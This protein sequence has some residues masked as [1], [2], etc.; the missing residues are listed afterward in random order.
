MAWNRSADN[1]RNPRGGQYCNGQKGRREIKVYSDNI[2]LRRPAYGCQS[3]LEQAA[4]QA[5]GALI[6]PRPRSRR[7]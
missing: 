2:G 7:W 4:R 1:I 3:A 5:P 6:C